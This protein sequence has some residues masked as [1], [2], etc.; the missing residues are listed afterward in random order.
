[1]AK[2][3]C[4]KGQAEGPAQRWGRG[5]GQGDVP[6]GPAVAVGQAWQAPHLL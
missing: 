4:P 6:G 3:S 2:L 5:G 1:M